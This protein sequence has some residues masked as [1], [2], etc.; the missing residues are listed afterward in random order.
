[1]HPIQTQAQYY[2]NRWSAFR[3]ANLYGLR[4]CVF[5]LQSMEQLQ[6]EDPKI[7]DLGCG[8]GWLTSILSMFGPTTGVELSPVAVEEA[9]RLHPSAQFVCAD[10]TKWECEPGAFDIV[11]SQEVIEHIE[12]KRA[13]LGVVRRALRPGGFLLMTTPNLDVLNAVPTAVRKAVWEIQPVELPL[14]RS[15]LDSLL[16]QCG[17]EVQRRGSVITGC[18]TMGIQRLLNSAKV[19]RVLSSLGMG[20][21][22]QRFLE[23]SGYG[24]YMT[25]V[26][27]SLRS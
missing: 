13:Y 22:W 11:V 8:A 2:D 24:M 7:C 14:K 19:N 17:F 6:L 9:R 26:A 18:G 10:A 4:R 23:R 27:R 15:E 12:D 3:Y 5:V 16:T 25:T 21:V 20:D 1:M